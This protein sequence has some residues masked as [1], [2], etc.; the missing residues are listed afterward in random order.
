MT[1]VL[2][3]LERMLDAG[4]RADV[5]RLAR[6]AVD[7]LTASALPAASARTPSEPAADEPG[8]LDAPSAEAGA[9]EA[10][11]L[12]DG[13]LEAG[14]PGVGARG[15]AAHEASLERALALY[16]RACAA[17]PPETID[18]ADWILG[19]SFGDPPRVVSLHDFADPLGEYGMAHIRATVDSR[20]AES[21][22]ED[23]DPVAERLAQELAALTGEVGG[24]VATWEKRL[25]NI[26]VS[27]KI[28]RVLRAAG[29]HSEALAHAAR[30]RSSDPS[31]I[32]DLLAAGR[33]DDAWTLT[34][35]LLAPQAGSCSH[36]EPVTP[37]APAGVVIDVYRRHVDSLIDGRDARS[38][39]ENYARAAVAL[40]RLRTLHRDA[41]TSA[42]F[43]DYL[44]GLVERHRRKSRLLDEIRAA[45]IALPTAPSQRRSRRS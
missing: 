28:V 19:V 41:G 34:R 18:L 21:T 22:V 45:R 11:A 42:E 33:D 39:A 1:A 36:A 9:L 29:R 24:L 31:R 40:R 7:R 2:D 17:H 4:T 43:A 6:L 12:E 16:A 14:A 5:A 13:A 26:E 15:T 8:A 35:N 32:G 27:L 20:L 30:A 3:T 25:P 37:A 44:A 23:P 38:P 10:G